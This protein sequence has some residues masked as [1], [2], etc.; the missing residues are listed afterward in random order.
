MFGRR[1][2]LPAV[3]LNL[4]SARKIAKKAMAEAKDS[5]TKTILNGK[6][7]ALKISASARRCDSCCRLTT[8][9]QI[10]FSASAV[11]WQDSCRAF[12]LLQP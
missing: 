6:Q 3:L 11:L 10:Q 2:L 5:M 12:Q 4:L 8:C 9:V 1:A 7:L